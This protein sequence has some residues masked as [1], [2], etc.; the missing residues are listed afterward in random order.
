MCCLVVPKCVHPESCASGAAKDYLPSLFSW[1]GL[2]LR[3]FQR[4]PAVTL[5]CH[6][7]PWS[8]QTGILR[9]RCNVFVGSVLCWNPTRNE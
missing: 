6:F 2:R 3:E 7:S 8:F 4:N 1:W 9:A 5:H